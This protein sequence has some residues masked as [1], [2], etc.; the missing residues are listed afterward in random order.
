MKPG[1][2]K[3][4]TFCLIFISANARADQDTLNYL[5]T[6]KLDEKGQ[7]LLERVTTHARNA[8]F[9][10]AIDLSQQLLDS[11]EGLRDQDPGTYG[12]IL[13]NHGIIQSASEE[14]ELGLSIIDSG[15]AIMET[16]INP[17][18]M[19]LVN[20]IAAKALTEMALELY[21]EGEDTLR[22]AQHITHRQDGVYSAEQISLVNYLTTAHLKQ[23][24]VL[25][26]D[27]EQLFSLRVS[28]QAYGPESTELLPVLNRL[29]SYFALRGST[30][31]I[32]APAEIRM[33][34]DLLFKHAVSM[35]QRAVL[36]IEQNFGDNDLRLVQPL[37]GLANARM[38]QVTSRKYAETALERSLDIVQD[39]PDSDVSDRARALVDLGDLYIITSDK[40]AGEV[41][42]EAWH[43]LQETPETQLVALSYFGTPT[44][45]YPR[46]D[47]MLY[48]SRVP[49]AAEVGSP[50]YVDLEYS[51][52]AEGKVNRIK[53]VDKNV[54]NEQVRILRAR[55]RA[56]RYRPRIVDAEIVP[57][58]GLMIHQP[59]MVINRPAYSDDGSA[60]EPTT[61]EEVDDEEIEQEPS[62]LLGP[63]ERDLEA[64][65]G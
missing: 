7:L 8:E 28:E 10:Y 41:Y 31:P 38:L 13:V 1:F 39:N 48:L 52:T 59:F 23:G 35:Y 43:L 26:A 33:E 56:S 51:V 14:Y 53:V 27:R 3:I 46:E 11:I 37:R 34:R 65:R 4:L 18:S 63:D 19:T 17:F 15:L 64:E 58:D 54:P 45:L 6:P 55:L 12:Q 25:D 47:R 2:S 16:K 22:R 40:R 57:T 49:D 60:E 30:L 44:R 5:Y 42:L 50:L 62:A 32:A 9:N 36:I 20:A 61:A 21:E 29:G 24:R